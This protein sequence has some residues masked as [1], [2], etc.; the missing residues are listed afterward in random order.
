MKQESK[1][2]EA[3]KQTIL[4]V[5]RKKREINKPAKEAA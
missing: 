1:I 4:V 3:R 2:I 5:Y